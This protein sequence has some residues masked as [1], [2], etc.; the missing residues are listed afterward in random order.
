LDS[1]V[2]SLESLGADENAIEV[3]LTRQSDE[4]A[5]E[6]IDRLELTAKLVWVPIS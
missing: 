2:A 1:Q 5:A 3:D 6:V 4:M